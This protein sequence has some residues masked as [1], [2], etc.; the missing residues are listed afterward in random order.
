ML[1][2]ARES[3]VSADGFLKC[4]DVT[5]D[6]RYRIPVDIGCPNPQG[7]PP[8]DN[9]SGLSSSSSL[10]SLSSTRP[11]SPTSTNSGIPSPASMG[12]SSGGATSNAVN[13]LFGLTLAG[14]LSGAFV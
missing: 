9:T 8:S 2:S 3:I 13:G 6:D 5:L 10:G 7:K 4:M 11:G 12:S 1:L 14:V